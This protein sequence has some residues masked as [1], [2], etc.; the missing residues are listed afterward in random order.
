[1]VSVFRAGAAGN[2]KENLARSELT[3]GLTNMYFNCKLRTPVLRYVKIN[4]DCR[5]AKS[6]MSD[7]K[8]LDD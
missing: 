6:Q 8:F 7:K 2:F 5:L 1:M 3:N 4:C